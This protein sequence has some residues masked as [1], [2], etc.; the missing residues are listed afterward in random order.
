MKIIAA[1]L[2]A[3]APAAPQPHLTPDGWGA[4]RIGMSKEQVEAAL[5]TKLEGEP[6]E[7]EYSCLDTRP[8]GPD[9]G[10][11][12][13]FEEYKLSRI[14]LWEPSRVTTPRGI[15][16]GSDAAA[17]RLAYG[18]RLQAE[19]H[20]YEDLPS[21]Y[22]TFW[23]VPDERGVRFETDGKQRVQAIHAGT[24]SIQYVEGCA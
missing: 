12:F 11:Y 17:V 18:K 23:T 19:P 9:Q 8:A 16:I 24:S 13:M 15:G 5:G 20:H 1:L 6:L 3:A 21:E 7:D 10:I 4:V 14:S 22:L 2:A